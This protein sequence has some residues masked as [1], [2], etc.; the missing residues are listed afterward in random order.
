MMY[1][2]VARCTGCGA[3]LDACP[4]GAIQLV[5]DE[6]GRHVQID[7]QMCQACEACVAACPEEAI[8]VQLEGELVSPEET[9]PAKAPS[10]AIQPAWPVPKAV[11]WAGTVLALAGREILPRVA[12]LVVDA[13]ARRASQPST[14]T[15][16]VQAPH[17]K[18]VLFRKNGFLAGRQHRQRQRRGR[19][20][21]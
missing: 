20:R 1:V 7:A 6:R 2:D 21:H 12:D 5:E 8:M 16:G 4:V 9:M 10:R 17:Q 13:V 14:P 19:A 18:P 3:C 15:S 11:V